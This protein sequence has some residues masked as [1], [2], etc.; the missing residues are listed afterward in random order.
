MSPW[1]SADA[2]RGTMCQEM[3]ALHEALAAQV[4]LV[5]VDQPAVRDEFREQIDEQSFFRR[6]VVVDGGQEYGEDDQ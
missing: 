4:D 6:G 2:L 1:P 5:A 3:F